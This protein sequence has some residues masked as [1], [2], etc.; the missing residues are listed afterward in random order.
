MGVGGTA[1]ERLLRAK[2]KSEF[3][4]GDGLA[5]VCSTCACRDYCS[6]RPGCPNNVLIPPLQRCPG[7]PA[8]SSDVFSPV[9]SN[10]RVVSVCWRRK[11]RRCLARAKHSPSGKH[12][13]NITLCNPGRMIA[14]QPWFH[15]TS[16]GF[17]ALGFGSQGSPQSITRR[18]VVE[19]HK[20]LPDGLTN[21][22][23]STARHRPAP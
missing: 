11:R 1:R 23:A 17:R 22:V 2:K 18:L 10:R 15:Q 13:A 8:A 19:T 14:W 16:H 7:C 21:F 20:Q 6:M 9:F 5:A 12:S 3:K 4:I